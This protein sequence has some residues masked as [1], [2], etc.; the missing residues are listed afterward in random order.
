VTEATHSTVSADA[1]TIQR[2]RT[3]ALAMSR[4]R[5]FF[6]RQDSEQ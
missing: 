1:V 3:A 2:R 5:T 6:R 4:R